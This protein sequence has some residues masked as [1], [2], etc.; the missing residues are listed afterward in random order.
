MVSKRILKYPAYREFAVS[1]KHGMHVKLMNT[2]D[3][4]VE[5]IP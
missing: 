3:N 1:V 5:Q 4:D 2:I